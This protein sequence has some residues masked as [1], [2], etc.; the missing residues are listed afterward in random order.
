MSQEHVPNMNQLTID[1]NM[2]ND[3]INSIRR[4][5][6]NYHNPL[7]YYISFGLDQ[8]GAR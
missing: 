7:A 5:I 2:S 1:Q 8:P 3:G 4:A 6:E